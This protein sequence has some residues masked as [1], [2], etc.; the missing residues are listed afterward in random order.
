MSPLVSKLPIGLIANTIARQAGLDDGIPGL[1]STMTVGDVAD[2]VKPAIPYVKGRASQAQ[3]FLRNK[4]DNHI[5]PSLASPVAAGGVAGGFN[6]TVAKRQLNSQ[7]LQS[8]TGG[9][10][11]VGLGNKFQPLSG[12]E[13]SQAE[14]G[15]RRQLGFL[16]RKSMQHKVEQG[17]KEEAKKIAKQKI[18]AAVKKATERGL[19]R[20]LGGTAAASIVGFIVTYALWTFQFWAGNI[21]KSK[22]IPELE[23]W[24]IFAWIFTSILLAG[25]LLGAIFIINLLVDPWLGG[26]VVWEAITDWIARIVGG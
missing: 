4:V 22:I 7:K 13:G 3:S 12:A 16:R 8:R 23:W 6:P 9:K 25:L 26:E 11:P 18:E 20:L 24:E 5:A 1:K 10:L 2:M 21:L 15:Y 14:Q 17:L 19:I